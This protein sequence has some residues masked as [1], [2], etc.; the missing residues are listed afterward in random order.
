MNPL[1]LTGEV[2]SVMAALGANGS[3]NSPAVLS[4]G[5]VGPYCELQ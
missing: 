1:L 5:T 3:H 2:P 4:E